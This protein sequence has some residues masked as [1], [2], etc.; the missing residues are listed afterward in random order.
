M[1]TDKANGELYKSI[2]LFW[3]IQVCPWVVVNWSE[4]TKVDADKKCS[5]PISA[6]EIL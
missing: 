2:Q 4:V 3:R 5:V 1:Y 6:N